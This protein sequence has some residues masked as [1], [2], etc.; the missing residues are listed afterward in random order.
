M[1]ERARFPGFDVK[2]PWECSMGCVGVGSAQAHV[3]G[4]PVAQKNLAGP[5]GQPRAW[6]AGHT[7][8]Q[9]YCMGLQAWTPEAG[10]RVLYSLLCMRCACGKPCE[11]C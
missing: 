9:F 4:G 10:R 1:L 5:S 11:G 2:A 6:P 7:A 3:W 8:V